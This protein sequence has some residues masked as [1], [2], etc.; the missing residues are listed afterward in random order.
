MSSIEIEIDK[1]VNSM[2]KE[3]RYLVWMKSENGH[4]SESSSN[5]LRIVI[6]DINRFI[7]DN[8]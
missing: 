1:M 4:I 6:R 2:T 7:E 8:I 5:D 3:F